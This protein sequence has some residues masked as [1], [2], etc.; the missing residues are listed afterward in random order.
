MCS[1][2][3]FDLYRVHHFLIPCNAWLPLQSCVVVRSACQL[4]TSEINIL[5]NLVR[6][7]H[8]YSNKK[9]Q[10]HLSLTKQ[11]T[12][13][14]ENNQATID[15]FISPFTIERIEMAMLGQYS[16]R[17]RKANNLKIGYSEFTQNLAKCITGLSSCFPQLYDARIM[18]RKV[19]SAFGYVKM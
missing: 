11:A 3:F 10:R 19:P 12:V 8:F 7:R 9:R 4:M 18:E 14:L 16:T 15:E 2:N 1:P 6:Q 17:S 5:L 13:L